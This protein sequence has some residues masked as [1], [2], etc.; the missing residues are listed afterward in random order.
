MISGFF[1][2]DVHIFNSE[3][4]TSRDFTSVENRGSNNAEGVADSPGTA[5]RKDIYFYFNGGHARARS[6]N[7][8]FS[9]EC[10]EDRDDHKQDKN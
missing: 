10:H 1:G 7:D 5:A 4:T 2:T 6:V 3:V 8:L 9:N